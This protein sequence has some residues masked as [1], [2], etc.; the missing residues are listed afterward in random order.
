MR[1]ISACPTPE[2]NPALQS[3]VSTAS[4]YRAASA[5]HERLTSVSGADGNSGKESLWQL[6]NELKAALAQ[7]DAAASD[8]SLPTATVQRM[9]AVM[10]E[11]AQNN[12]VQRALRKAARSA[13]ARADSL[14][15]DVQRLSSQVSLNRLCRAQSLRRAPALA[16]TALRWHW[17]PHA[18]D[19]LSMLSVRSGC[20]THMPS[21]LVSMYNPNT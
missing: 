1:D 10:R 9:L 8:V 2:M 6:R 7:Q 17:L 20:G 15:L 13:S 11:H 21:A 14:Q 16:L 5:D 18:V 12:R 3:N 19:Q 4:F